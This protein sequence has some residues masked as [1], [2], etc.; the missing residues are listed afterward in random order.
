MDQKVTNAAI[1]LR[2]RVKK[3]GHQEMNVVLLRR[4]RNPKRRL[5]RSGSPALIPNLANN[6]R[7]ED[8][9]G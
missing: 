8:L 7:V 4:L 3:R 6:S 2:D 9:D 5:S 1:V